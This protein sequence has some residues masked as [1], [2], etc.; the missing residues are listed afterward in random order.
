MFGLIDLLLCDGRGGE[1]TS[2]IFC[3][4]LF[5]VRACRA[6][7]VYCRGHEIILQCRL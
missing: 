2:G 7:A 1:G 4:Y 5:V 6:V 3:G